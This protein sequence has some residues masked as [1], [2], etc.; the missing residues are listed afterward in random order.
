M[1][2]SNPYSK[3]T[4]MLLNLLIFF[5]GYL[6]LFEI[7]VP[8]LFPKKSTGGCGNRKINNDLL[9][10]NIAVRGH[11]S[12]LSPQQKAC[13]AIEICDEEILGIGYIMPEAKHKYKAE[14]MKYADKIFSKET[15]VRQR[16]GSLA[17]HKKKSTKNRRK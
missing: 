8:L 3:V 6:I 11:H 12:D 14:I 4:D 7:L 17:E 16:R 1:E 15:P 5:C 10:D 13:I 9:P 2:S